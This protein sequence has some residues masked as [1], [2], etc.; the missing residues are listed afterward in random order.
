MPFDASL[1]VPTLQRTRSLVERI[2][3]AALICWLGVTVL[4]AA[5]DV[6]ARAMGGNAAVIWLMHG[7]GLTFAEIWITREALRAEG[8][9]PVLTFAGIFT[10]YLLSL[11]VGLGIFFGLLLFILPGLY[12]AAR[13]YL[14]G[15]IL[16]QEGGGT[17]AAIWRSWDLLQRH[18]LTAFVLGLFLGGA[19]LSPLLVDANEMPGTGQAFALLLGFNVISAGGIVGGYIASVALYLNIERPASTL[20]E[21][22]G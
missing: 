21:I 10:L 3:H 16:V 5:A 7:F 11:I 17:G 15:A 8:C 22:F 19:A 14:A 18:W 20:Q 6:A 9:R 12:F 2:P 13:W 1:L 4:G